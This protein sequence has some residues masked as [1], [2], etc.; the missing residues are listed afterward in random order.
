MKKAKIVCTLGPASDSQEVITQL[1]KAGMNVARLNFSHGTH[2]YHK[3]VIENVRA[4]SVKLNMPVAI[5]Q[6]LQG[7]KIRVGFVENGAVQLKVRKTVLLK[8]GNEASNDRKIFISY[9]HLLSDVKVGNRVLIDDGHIQMVVK[10]KTDDALVAEIKEGGVLKNKKGVNLPDT[11]ISLTSFTEKD[12][13]D[14]AFGIKAG[15][16]WVALSFV[17]S[18]EDIIKVKDFLKEKNAAI[19]VIAKIEK[20]EAV[21]NIN[22]II[23]Q[24]DGIMIARGDLA[25]EMSPQAVP[26]LQKELIVKANQAGKI[27]IVATQMLESMTESMTP[28]RAEANDVANAVMDGADALML[29]AETTVGK[30]PVKTVAVMRQIIEYTEKMTL[31]LLPEDSEFDRI[32]SSLKKN[33]GFP[34]A[35]AD[36]ACKASEDVKSKLIIAFTDS[37]YT[38]LLLSKNKPKTPILAFTSQSHVMNQMS[39]FWGVRPIWIRHLHSTEEMIE[40]VEKVLV[41]ANILNKKDIITIVASSPLSIKGKT[42]FLKLHKIGEKQ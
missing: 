8:P 20:P 2:D 24:A 1:M 9:P 25:V 40:E 17:R 12:Q 29:S 11:S 15:V 23:E 27:V 41:K 35:I 28:T 13:A 21:G 33:K 22:R 38:A 39:L 30:Y 5:L 19:P 6:D 14:L 4:C 32:S 31:K 42:N 10:E 36:A 34:Y 16:D 7:I 37:G 18:H 26:V 3:K